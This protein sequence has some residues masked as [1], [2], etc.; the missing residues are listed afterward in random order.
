MSSD[1]KT[2]PKASDT[3]TDEVH[4]TLKGTQRS[5][6]SSDVIDNGYV[7]MRNIDSGKL[8]LLHVALTSKIAD[9]EEDSD[10]IPLR[11][12][13]SNVNTLMTSHDDLSRG[14][15][16]VGPNVP[17]LRLNSVTSSQV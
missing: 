1:Q 10:E 3:N 16:L 2:L 13:W 15:S 12:A 6:Q 4:G 5:L 9:N 14:N 11:R 17:P 7:E 8:K